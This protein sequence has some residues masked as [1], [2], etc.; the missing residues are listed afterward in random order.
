MGYHK[1]TAILMH[2]DMLDT[3][4]TSSHG[5]GAWE[6]VPEAADRATTAQDVYVCSAKS[7]NAYKASD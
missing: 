7:R 5:F 2:N 3:I 6:D 1:R 4:A